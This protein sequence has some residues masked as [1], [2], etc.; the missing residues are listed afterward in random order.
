[1]ADIANKK[2]NPVIH[3]IKLFLAN[4]IGIW[5]SFVSIYLIT[6]MFFGAGNESS[7]YKKFG[8]MIV[9]II[10]WIVSTFP[11]Y[12]RLL[13]ERKK[14]KPEKFKIFNYK[15]IIIINTLI[16]FGSVLG[17]QIDSSFT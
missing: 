15:L 8:I 17:I 1:M 6:W 13:N 3:F 9:I 14:V 10:C 5:I 4:L 7:L 12:I 16:L 11:F 2:T